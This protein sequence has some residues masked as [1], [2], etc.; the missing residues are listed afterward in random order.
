MIHRKKEGGGHEF[1]FAVSESPELEIMGVNVH[2]GKVEKLPDLE[3]CTREA[4]LPFVPEYALDYFTHYMA[5]GENPG[6]AYL[7][8]Q[9]RASSC[10]ADMWH[11]ALDKPKG[12]KRM[13][14][15]YTDEEYEAAKKSIAEADELISPGSSS[16]TR[17]QMAKEDI[18]IYEDLKAGKLPESCDII[19]LPQRLTCMR[20]ASG[21]S[22]SEC[23]ARLGLEVEHQRRNERNEY[24][25]VTSLALQ[26]VIDAL[27]VDV[28]VVAED[29]AT[30]KE[31]SR[32]AVKELGAMLTAFRI[33][34]TVS[35]EQL[36]NR[37]R[38]EHRLAMMN[39]KKDY[40]DYLMANV[41]AADFTS[42]VRATE[43]A[44][45]DVSMTYA[46]IV[47]RLLKVKLTVKA[48]LTK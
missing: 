41:N 40:M 30:G 13:S 14:F 10:T 25:G 38:A 3:T 4:I 23:A 33:G 8:A 37:L 47:A 15:I 46:A 48:K 45:A 29:I 32:C 9:W 6:N 18:S 28:T 21:L 27:P 16:E 39:G 2:T 34:K 26:F 24:Y 19:H 17:L 7:L 5:E 35:F 12:E 42:V 20:I 22:Q 36:Y 31:L 11:R 43:G 44:N 1:E